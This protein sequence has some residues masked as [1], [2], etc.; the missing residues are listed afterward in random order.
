MQLN[1]SSTA[2]SAHHISVAWSPGFQKFHTYK[3]QIL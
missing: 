1:F 3:S 2:K